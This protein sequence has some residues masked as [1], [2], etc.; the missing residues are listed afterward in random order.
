LAD[1]CSKNSANDILKEIA[2]KQETKKI[3]KKQ[4]SFFNH[5]RRMSKK[6]NTMFLELDKASPH[7]VQ[8]RAEN[9]YTGL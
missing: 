8:R 4:Q 9:S 5:M 6:A 2:R 1:S 7:L 3:S